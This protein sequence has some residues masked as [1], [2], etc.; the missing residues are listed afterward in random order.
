MRCGRAG[1]RPHE[2][3]SASVLPAVLWCHPELH[4]LSAGRTTFHRPVL[5]VDPV[6]DTSSPQTLAGYNHA[7]DNSNTSSDPTGLCRKSLPDEPPVNC[8][9]NPSAEGAGTAGAGAA[10]YHPPVRPALLT[11]P[12]VLASPAAAP[13]GFQN[14]ATCP[15]LGGACA[16]VPAG[17][18][19]AR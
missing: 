3:V 12:A 9:G 11:N 4:G 8:S 7:A 14:S 16:A 5:S 2:W 17:A 13:V 6:L 18:G 10:P 15:D 1:D 19:S